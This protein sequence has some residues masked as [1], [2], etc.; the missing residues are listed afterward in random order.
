MEDG[1]EFGKM[2][3][4]FGFAQHVNLS[5]EEPWYKPMME[6]KAGN[7]AV[8]GLAANLLRMLYN[9]F[10]EKCWERG[11]IQ[12]GRVIIHTTI[13]DEILLSYHKT[14]N[15]FEL[16]MVLREAFVV[17]YRKFPPLF[18]GVN[19]AR[20]WGDTKEDEF[21]IPSLLLEA[22]AKEYKN[23]KRTEDYSNIDHVEFF[24]KDILRYKR[25]RVILELE[26]KSFDKTKVLEMEQFSSIFTSY[27][28]R[29]LLL[30]DLK[31]SLF[32]I[33]D[34]SDPV[35]VLAST[36]LHFLSKY[37]LDDG[38]ILKIRLRKK[39]FGITNKTHLTFFESEHNFINGIK[40]QAPT[41]EAVADEE[42]E[43]DDIFYSF[44]E[45]DEESYVENDMSLTNWSLPSEYNPYALKAAEEKEPEQYRNFAV[46]AGNLIIRCGSF[47]HIKL[48]KAF[49]LGKT[50][51]S[52]E[53]VKVFCMYR[54]QTYQL[55]AYKETVISE[56]DK[57]E[58]LWT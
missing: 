47:D 32:K 41:N 56:M 43:E 30:T 35:E 14:I 28:V 39:L 51:T 19:I 44:N 20:T 54:A 12:D 58:E 24:L 8:Q 53:S 18:I 27:Y 57:K 40:P 48:I 4:T 1:V 9:R 7:F 34:Y 2:D 46:R 31:G 37:V 15:P 17:Q 23:G 22:Y 10:V 42:D 29:T 33:G 16:L 52:T 38:E 55:G 3:N 50:T 49:L 21:E 45:Q 25:E 6:R 11:W 26:A 5:R 36:L 13:Y